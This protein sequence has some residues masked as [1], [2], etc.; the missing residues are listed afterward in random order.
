MESL[1]LLMRVY[2]HDGRS[3]AFKVVHADIDDTDDEHGE[4]MVMASD[5]IA[6]AVAAC[7]GVHAI[8]I[9]CHAICHVSDYTSVVQ[10]H[11]ASIADLCEKFLNKRYAPETG[12]EN[13]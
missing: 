10:N 13:T 9:L 12:S 1:D 6:K 2:S 3:T 5:E 8:P 11:D 4:W 7:F